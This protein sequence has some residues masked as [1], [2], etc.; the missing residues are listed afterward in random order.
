MRMT[1][2]T[3]AL[4]LAALSMSVGLA[5]VATPAATHAQGAPGVRDGKAIAEQVCSECHAVGSGRRPSPN[6]EAPPFTV[7]AE[8]PGMT[9]IAL[10]VA[11][12]TSHRNMPN[13]IL[14]DDELKGI[15]AYIMSLQ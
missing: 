6:G 12:R 13:I 8:T 4:S 15:V 5:I 2:M 7:I 9:P 10:T 14:S 11:L 1:R 3:R